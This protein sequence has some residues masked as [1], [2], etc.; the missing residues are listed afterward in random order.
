MPSPVCRAGG[1]RRE[2]KSPDQYGTGT[3]KGRGQGKDCGR[4]AWRGPPG[5]GPHHPD[6]REK[7]MP[8]P[9][10]T[11]QRPGR[12]A[13]KE[14]GHT[15]NRMPAREKKRTSAARYMIFPSRQGAGENGLL[16]LEHFPFETRS[17]SNHTACRFTKKT[18]FFRS[19][20][21]GRRYAAA[22]RF[23]LFKGKA[24]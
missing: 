18:L 23:A 14:S 21:A 24:L 7:R 4:E 13:Q 3:A 15:C 5:G 2:G 11:G 19:I 20:P 8:C 1:L 17:I 22:S 16:S 9:V 6:A 10:A 12:C